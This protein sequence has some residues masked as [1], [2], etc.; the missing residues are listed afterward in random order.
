MILFIRE[1]VCILVKNE[2]YIWTRACNVKSTLFI[3]RQEDG[4]EYVIE[5]VKQFDEISLPVA[6]LR[7]YTVIR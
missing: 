1:F 3:E 7:R 5:K 2:L 6:K 4:R